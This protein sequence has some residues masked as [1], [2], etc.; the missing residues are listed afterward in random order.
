V[1]R[2]ERHCAPH[3]R[4]IAG[5]A[6]VAAVT[7]LLLIPL[8]LP[9][10]GRAPEEEGTAGPPPGAQ[11]TAPRTVAIIGIDGLEWEILRPLLARGELPTIASLVERGTSGWLDTMEPTLSPAIWTSVATGKLPA[12]HG[13]QH[14]AMPDGPG[15]I[16]L[17]DSRD[18]QTKALWNMFSERR[19]STWVIGWWMTFPAEEVFG[20][21]VAQTNAAAQ[22]DTRGGRAIWRGTLVPG[23]A[24]QVHPPRLQEAVLTFAQAAAE[25]APARAVELFGPFEHP[26]SELTRRLWDNSLWAFR[27]DLVNRRVALE[28]LRA[29]PAPDLFMLYFGGTDVVAHRFFRHRQ[30]GAFKH[31]PPA[32]ELADFGSLIDDYYRWI[33][34]VLGEVITALGTGADVIVLSDHGVHAVNLDQEFSPDDPPEDVNSGHHEDAPAGVLIAAG[35]RISSAG[36]TGAGAATIDLAALPH[37]GNVLDIAPTVLALA[38]L[39]VGEDMDGSVME[40]LLAPGLLARNP[41]RRIASWDA[42][43]V[44]RPRAG[45]D[46]PDEASKERIEQLRALGYIE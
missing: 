9:A 27:A 21:M 44:E 15:H 25:E 14:F 16:R 28:T 29:E 2:G 23:L 35:P 42:S 5:V 24:G 34:G 20:L 33:D 43:G 40:D 3:R 41:L 32:V 4:S 38:G 13:I 30:P 18:R 12:K 17:F 6:P 39:P 1:R 45:P 19:R 46:L 22:F 31:P 26:L 8:L 7:A 10:C 11:R 37:L 36:R